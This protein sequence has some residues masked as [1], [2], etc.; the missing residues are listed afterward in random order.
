MSARADM[1]DDAKEGMMRPASMS[2]GGHH[3]AHPSPRDAASDLAGEDGGLTFF[4]RWSR[5]KRGLDVAEMPPE[6]PADASNPCTSNPPSALVAAPAM[7]PDAVATMAGTGAQTDP[8][9]IDAATDPMCGGG[10]PADDP[11]DPIDPRTGKRMSEL[12]DADMPDLETLD[13]NAD[14]RA[15][16]AANVSSA[17]RMKALTR[18]FH[19]PKF[20]QVC[21]CAEYADD[22]TNFL[23]MGDIV[24]HDLQQAIV[25]EAG[26]LV[27]RL[28]GQGV[29]IT[30]EQAR[31]QIAAEF[32]GE[33][34][35]LP[36]AGTGQDDDAF[37]DAVPEVSAANADSMPH[38]VEHPPAFDHQTTDAGGGTPNTP[39]PATTGPA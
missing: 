24:P 28:T 21:L 37:G 22:Y 4:S 39:R 2:V 32:R 3:A 27:E 25:R 20:N 35:V 13:E 14:L 18:V 16:M 7:Q 6:A 29:E 36:V 8:Q 34:V 15:F 9:P 5:R 10:V 17:L 19:T 31:A 38:G 26:K 33:R 11:S 1:S 30:P 23:P 12:T